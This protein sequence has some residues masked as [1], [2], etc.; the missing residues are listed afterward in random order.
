MSASQ[1]FSITVNNINHA[2]TLTSP[3]NQAVAEGATRAIELIAGD[4]DSDDLL[5]FT[6]T[7]LPEFAT[8]TD[9]GD[10]SAVLSLSPSFDDTG[11][12][13]NV[14][15]TVTD[16]LSSPLYVSVSFTIVVTN[17]NQAPVLTDPGSQT[18]A[19]AAAL[20]FPIQATDPDGNA[21]VLSAPNLPAFVTLIDNGDGSGQVDLNPGYFDAGVYDIMLV[22]T[23]D[24]LVSL[25]TSKTIS[26]TVTNQNRPPTITKLGVIK[27]VEVQTI[28]RQVAAK[29][30]DTDDNLTFSATGLP[31]DLSI[32]PNTGQILGTLGYSTAGQYQV[33]I[34]VSDGT[35]S[36]STSFT[37]KIANTPPANTWYLAEGFTGNGFK[38]FIL[39][40]NPGNKTAVTTV[41][42]L[43]EG[44]GV[45]TRTFKIGAKSRST[46][47][48]QD[49]DQ[50]GPG[51][52][53]STKVETSQRVI[54]ERSMYW[55]NGFDTS[56]GHATTAIRVPQRTW[57]LAEGYTG[58]GFETYIL[59][60]NPNS[61]TANVTVNYM[62]ENGTLTRRVITVPG[63]SRYTIA[64]HDP[65]QIGPDKTFSTKIVSSQ[66][67]IVERSM[68]FPNDGNATAAVPYPRQRWY[69]AEGFTGSDMQTV[70]SILNPHSAKTKV[71]LIY[72]TVDGG[73]VRQIITIGPNSRATIDVEQVPGMGP[74][75]AFSTTII[76]S[77]S[78]VVERAMYWPNG[79]G[80]MA[81]HA[82]S[83]VSKLSKVWNLADGSTSDGFQTFILIQN[84]SSSTATVKVSYMLQDGTIVNR[85]V[86]VPKKGR[87]TI[88][89]NDPSQV[90]PDMTFSTRLVSN[91]PVAV[92]RA[93][94]FP[95]GGSITTGVSG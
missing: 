10:R 11:V 63:N 51:V 28:S 94:Y 56:G 87:L 2:P 12:Y 74:D 68:Y 57:Y 31:A 82:S 58:P 44:G 59:V 39:I 46:I 9:R 61:L 27:N 73:K 62:E 66:P 92:E 76:G 14:T 18:V 77:S 24:G 7:G 89:T 78:I 50:L 71:N 30:L 54:V 32:D 40:Q 55:P 53:F 22:A 81:G 48:V 75:K 19:E 60:Q 34:T 72:S 65:E 26:I 6:S 64:T 3:G 41:S 70:I 43:L 21:V 16:N 42:Y 45:E 38:T 1:S 49:P 37:W 35:D 5:T 17:T 33:V 88:L 67:V 23:D 4:P 86:K 15:I 20:S 29:D 36:D 8:L 95:N 83:G 80:S 84:P 93:M 47:A 69:L 52:A 90:G 79:D 13:E 25:S 91:L 85:T